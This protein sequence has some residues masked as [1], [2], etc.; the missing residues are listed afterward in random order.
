MKLT[1]WFSGDLKPHRPGVYE[2]DWREMDWMG[3]R[4][5]NEWDGKRW[6]LGCYSPEEHAGLKRRK[7]RVNPDIAKRA[8]RRWRGLR[9]DA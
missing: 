1:P 6:R 4:W 3:G 7:E 2:C 5:Y 9:S 8:L